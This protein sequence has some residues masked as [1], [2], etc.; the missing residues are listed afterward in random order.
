M[1]GA[2]VWHVW[3]VCV[4]AL[5]EKGRRWYGRIGG[6]RRGWSVGDEVSVRFKSSFATYY[7][8]H[9]DFALHNSPRFLIDNHQ[10]AVVVALIILVARPRPIPLPRDRPIP[11][12]RH[13]VERLKHVNALR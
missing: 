9:P 7:A 5:T 12:L 8:R 4:V 3:I 11:I 1:C 13:L 2:F 10:I 6:E